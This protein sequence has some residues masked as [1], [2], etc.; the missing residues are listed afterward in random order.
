MLEKLR[1]VALRYEDLQTQLGE[2]KVY[3]DS[4]KLKNITREVRELEP[5]VEAYRAFTAAQEP[6]KL[7]AA[8]ITT[9]AII[10][11]WLAA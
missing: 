5:V 3:G 7:S 11:T 2:P 8:F 10:T 4:E 9:P 1:G 6:R